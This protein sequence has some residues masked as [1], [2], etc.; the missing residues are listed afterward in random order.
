MSATDAAAKS[1]SDADLGK[2]ASRMTQEMAD[3]LKEAADDV[4]AT[5]FEPSRNP[6]S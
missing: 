2:H 5:A 1:V 3:R 4:V 6:N